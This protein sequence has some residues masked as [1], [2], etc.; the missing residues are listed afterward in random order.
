MRNKWSSKPSYW[1]TRDALQQ[2][3]RYDIRYQISLLHTSFLPRSESPLP[4][5]HMKDENAQAN[6][7]HNCCSNLRDSKSVQLLSDVWAVSSKCETYL[8]QASAM[9]RIELFERV[10]E[11][12]VRLRVWNILCKTHHSIPG[13][14][15]LQ[16]L[17]SFKQQHRVRTPGRPQQKI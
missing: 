13:G 3:C 5:K 1:L 16:S 2:G 4:V 9:F 10:S 7:Q 15:D 12:K 17:F 11:K 14:K 6:A 8:H